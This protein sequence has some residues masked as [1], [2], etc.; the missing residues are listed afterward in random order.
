MLRDRCIANQV[1]DE[2]VGRLANHPRGSSN[3][4]PEYLGKMYNQMNRS[5]SAMVLI[6]GIFQVEF[7]IY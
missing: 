7:I 6:V 4:N 5:F 2:E 1:S 3:L